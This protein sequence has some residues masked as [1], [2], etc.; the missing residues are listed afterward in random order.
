MQSARAPGP[1]GLPV[2]G[3]TLQFLRDPIAFYRTCATYGDVVR[4]DVLGDELYFV[5]DP[6]EIQRVFV[7]DAADFRKPDLLADRAGELLGDGV[8]LSEGAT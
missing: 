2:V 1:R 6:V 3:N 7:T 5:F 8:F 4:A